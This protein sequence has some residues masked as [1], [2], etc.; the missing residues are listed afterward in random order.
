MGLGAS[1]GRDTYRNLVENLW[2]EWVREQAQVPGVEEENDGV[3]F[4]FLDL[5]YIL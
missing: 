5:I 1:T 4:R 2:E 3:T